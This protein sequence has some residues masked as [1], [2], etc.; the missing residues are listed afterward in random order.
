MLAHLLTNRGDLFLPTVDMDA[1]DDLSHHQGHQEA[2][3]SI[4][5]T[6]GFSGIANSPRVIEENGRHHRHL[7]QAIEWA[8]GLK[9]VLTYL[10]LIA[11]P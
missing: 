2:V 5:N 7:D 11:Y 10:E 4:I 9:E 3:T 1:V 6:M 8:R